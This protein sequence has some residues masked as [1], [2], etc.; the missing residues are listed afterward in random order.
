MSL[1]WNSSLHLQI[2]PEGIAGTL[3]TG[4]PRPRRIRATAAASLAADPSPAAPDGESSCATLAVEAL[5]AV[6]D[7]L[8]LAS[9]LRGARVVVEVADPLVQFDVAEGDFAALG[10]RQLQSIATACMGE[11]L[12]NALADHEVRWSLQAGERHLVIAALPRAWIAALAEEVNLRGA[13]LASVQPA[14]A[15]RWNA[16]ARSLPTPN[17]VFASTSGAHAVVSCVVGR[18]LCAVSTGPWQDSEPAVAAASAAATPAGSLSLLDERAE[19]LLASLG[20]EP[21]DALT[22][23]LVGA[24]VAASAAPSRWTVIEPSEVPA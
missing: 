11:L 10:D 7:E 20:V 21:G 23:L 17:A 14:F 22:C 16:Y 2:A 5:Q 8:G 9:R 19:R 12:G 13:R 3:T 18:A 6:L 24:D 4:W 15:R 1:P